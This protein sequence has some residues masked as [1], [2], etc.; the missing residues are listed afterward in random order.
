[1]VAQNTMCSVILHSTIIVVLCLFLAIHFMLSNI[2]THIVWCGCRNLARIKLQIME[3]KSSGFFVFFTL[4]WYNDGKPSNLESPFW[5][6]LLRK[7]KIEKD[8]SGVFSKKMCHSATETIWT[9]KLDSFISPAKHS[10]GEENIAAFPVRSFL[11][12][13]IIISRSGS[14]TVCTTLTQIRV[15]LWLEYSRNLQVSHSGFRQWRSG[16]TTRGSC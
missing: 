16:K 5:P 13:I 12:E 4:V 14:C 9:N 6:R 15:F 8:L 10:A 11:G 1:M 3:V 2:T 7:I